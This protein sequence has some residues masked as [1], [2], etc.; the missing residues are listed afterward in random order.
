LADYQ[1]SRARVLVGGVER[2][3]TNV[4]MPISTW[5]LTNG[6]VSCSAGNPSNSLDVAAWD[7]TAWDSKDWNIT[8]GSST[9]ALTTWNTA[10][11]TRND[12]E[13]CTIRLLDDRGPGRTVVDLTLRR[14][15]RFVEG[16]IQNTSST[17]LGVV[18]TSG[19]VE[20]STS[21]ASSGYVRATSNDAQGNRFVVGSARSFTALTASGGLTKT[22]TTTL[23]FFIGAEVGGSAAPTGDQ[24]ATLVNQYLTAMAERTEGSVR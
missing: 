9:A 17:M 18:K 16:Y 8:F 3:A 10:Q 5:V 15:S 21:P 6:L 14:G 23:D 20:A 4:T 22:S 1:V 19:S 2:V 7:G 13:A 24:A 11:I 12:Y